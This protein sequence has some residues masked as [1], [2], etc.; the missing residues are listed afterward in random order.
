M[1]LGDRDI[2]ECVWKD[3]AVPETELTESTHCE[4]GHP[5]ASRGCEEEKCLVIEI[6]T[7][8]IYKV[9]ELQKPVK[10]SVTQKL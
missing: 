8:T 7:A 10:V 3:Q 9:L 4:V 2:Q 5:L 6:L 1:L